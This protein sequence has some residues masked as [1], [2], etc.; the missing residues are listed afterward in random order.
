MVKRK[1][2]RQEN[3]MKIKMNGCGN[4][5]TKAKKKKKILL[6]KDMIKSRKKL[7][8]NIMSLNKRKKT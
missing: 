3:K 5:K 6:K 4:L 1:K 8:K 2:K 7:P